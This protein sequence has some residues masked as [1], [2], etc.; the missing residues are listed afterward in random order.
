[1]GCEAEICYI[2]VPG[3][4]GEGTGTIEYQSV[5]SGLDCESNLRWACC[6]Q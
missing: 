4:W 5:I 3:V 6:V 1:M 2:K